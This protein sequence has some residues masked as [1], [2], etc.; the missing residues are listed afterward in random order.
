MG[1][2]FDDATSK[3]SKIQ[4]LNLKKL[5]SNGDKQISKTI[6]DNIYM[7]DE[8]NHPSYDGSYYIGDWLFKNL[9]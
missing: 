8:T 1:K 9:K 2:C 3:Q 5:L 6:I 7:Y 4:I